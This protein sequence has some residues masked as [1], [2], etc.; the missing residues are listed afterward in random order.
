[1]EKKDAV[2][3]V[4]FAAIIGMILGYYLA[5]WLYMPNYCV[6][7]NKA[8]RSADNSII[9][10][11]T[12]CGGVADII[13]GVIAPEQD[14]TQNKQISF[15][16]IGDILLGSSVGDVIK[17][18]GEDYIFKDVNAIFKET[19]FVVGNLECAIS[20]RGSPEQNKE[21]VFRAAPYTAKIIADAGIDA[22]SLANNHVLDFGLDALNDTFEHL[23]SNDVKYAGAGCDAESASKPVY[24]E[25][26]GVKIAFVASSHVIP[27]VSWTAGVN[28]PGVASTYNPAVICNEISNADKNADIVI[29]YLHWGMERYDIAELYQRNLAKKFI[30]CGADIVVGSH[31]HVVQGLEFYK[32]G[33][34]VYSLGNF[35]F[36]NTKK[37]TMIVKVTFDEQQ[38]NKRVEVI[39][40]E[41]INFAPN[42]MKDEKTVKAFIDSL[43]N[44]SYNVSIDEKGAAVNSNKNTKE[45]GE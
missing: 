21:F 9:K 32:H 24:A 2:L 45:M 3:I 30:D 5:I 10:Y 44:I 8:I 41:I 15:A 29:A 38:E 20:D 35:V 33:V 4:F 18:K 34:I 19:D 7:S 42:V 43:N 39:P 26:K 31:P 11:L 22:V 40:C 13:D 25:V 1:M 14:D 16:F 12:E 23:E 17:A 6:N 27:F 36:T 28:K 37:D